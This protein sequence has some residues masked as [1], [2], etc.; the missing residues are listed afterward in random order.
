MTTY[1]DLA[2]A[3]MDAGY[4][5][6]ADVQAAAAVLADAL[7]VEAAEDAEAAAMEDYNEQEDII[8][9]AEVWTAEDAAEGDLDLV[10]VDEDIIEDAADQALVDREIVMQAEAIIE[11]A[12]DDAAAALLAA[13]L[14]DEAEV[15]AVAL[16]LAAALE[17][18]AIFGV[19]VY[20]RCWLKAKAPLSEMAVALFVVSEG[21][22]MRFK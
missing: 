13:A 17:D 6:D 18:W 20:D 3:L 7:I 21:L 8:A 10:D 12:Y 15:E 9:E 19:P 22:M 1:L 4:V 2:R 11:A 14:I 5:S 16:A